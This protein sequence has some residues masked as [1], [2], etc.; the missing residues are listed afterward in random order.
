MVVVSLD[1]ETYKLY[2][3]TKEAEE[4]ILNPSCNASEEGREY[5][6][7]NKKAGYYYPVLNSKE[8]TLG[9]LLRSD[10]K[11]PVFFT[12]HKEM[13]KYILDMKI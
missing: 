7:K 8:F 4:F 12:N 10:R 3:G 1:V 6:R 5:F 13:L 2:D 11:K 9:A